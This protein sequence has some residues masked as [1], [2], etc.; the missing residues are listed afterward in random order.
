MQSTSEQWLEGRR[1]A[2][3]DDIDPTTNKPELATILGVP[4][5][6]TSALYSQS[7]ATGTQ[8]VRCSA[9]GKDAALVS[10]KLD[11]CGHFLRVG[12]SKEGERLVDV[13]KL[14]VSLLTI[15]FACVQ[16]ERAPPMQFVCRSQLVIGGNKPKDSSKIKKLLG[17][18]QV[19]YKRTLQ[20]SYFQF[21]CL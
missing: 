3:P 17:S 20:N 2:A 7:A 16:N 6:P 13:R 12:S 4:L 21:H 10:A 1:R 9:D 11:T 19:Q 18:D 15:N 5:P 14:R 8:F